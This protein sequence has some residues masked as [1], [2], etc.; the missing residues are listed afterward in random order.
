MWKL[1]FY[2]S[3]TFSKRFLILK[4][5]YSEDRSFIIYSLCEAGMLTKL[6]TTVKRSAILSECV[7]RSQINNSKNLL[8]RLLESLL[9]LLA[10][11]TLLA[12][13]NIVVRSLEKYFWKHSACGLLM[14]PENLYLKTIMYIDV[15]YQPDIYIHPA[16]LADSKTSLA[17]FGN[18]CLVETLLLVQDYL[19]M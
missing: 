11:Y 10:C 18:H 2:V 3:R 7:Q 4:W 1:L 8:T 12:F 9:H 5:T 6:I 17:M 14:S 16:S 15:Y 13:C 19:L